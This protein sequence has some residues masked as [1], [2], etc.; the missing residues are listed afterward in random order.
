MCAKESHKEER[1]SVQR[2][3]SVYKKR[4]GGKPSAH[5]K[6]VLQPEHV[7]P[8]LLGGG[9]GGVVHADLALSAQTDLRQHHHA[10]HGARD[11]HVIVGHVHKILSGLGGHVAEERG[12]GT[13]TYSE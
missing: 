12:R 13:G 5:L 6:Q 10:E 2:E 7:L 3:K 4:E 9:G 1:V 11:V 8:A